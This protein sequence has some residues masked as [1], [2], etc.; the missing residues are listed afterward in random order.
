ML[1]LLI[2]KFHNDW[3]KTAGAICPHK[4]KYRF[5][6]TQGQVTVKFLFVLRL[7]IPVNNL[8]VMS[9]RSNYEMNSLI[10][11]NVKLVRDFMLILV[12]VSFIMIQ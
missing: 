1:A 9:G 2:C 6:C 5:F 10:W 7:N 11:P 4:D 3:I 12:S 8:S